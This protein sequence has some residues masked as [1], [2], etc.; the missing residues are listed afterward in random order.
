MGDQEC[1]GDDEGGCEQSS[2]AVTMMWTRADR[3]CRSRRG[4]RGF[5]RP[6][7]P[8]LW[9]R[10]PWSARCWVHFRTRSRPGDGSGLGCGRRALAQAVRRADFVPRTER[11]SRS[12]QSGLR[13]PGTL[14][15]LRGGKAVGPF[16]GGKGPTG[17]AGGA[18]RISRPGSSNRVGS[19]RAASPRW[20]RRPRWRRGGGTPIGPGRVGQDDGHPRQSAT[21]DMITRVGWV[22][23]AREIVSE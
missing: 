21:I 9:D 19:S 11:T 22:E 8:A 23:D 13:R 6:I 1:L 2:P 4:S 10:G 15:G 16:P 17:V 12:E 18:G 3:A 7:V 5:T 20:C 14:S